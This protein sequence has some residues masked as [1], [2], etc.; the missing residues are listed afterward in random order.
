MLIPSGAS[1]KSIQRGTISITYPNYTNT[2]SIT[3]V[4][5]SKCIL[6]YC[7][8]DSTS[9]ECYVS[10]TNS[11]TVTASCTPTG[12]TIIVSYEVIEFN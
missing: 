6:N 8:S 12:L 5:T 2:A 4:D 7:G 10:L 9:Y 11:T 1:I 3:S